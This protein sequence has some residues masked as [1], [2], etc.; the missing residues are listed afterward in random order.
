MG[1]A[2]KR[3]HRHLLCSAHPSV[4]HRLRS[5]C[6]AEGRKGPSGD[7]R[8]VSGSS[9]PREETAASF[10]PQ[11]WSSDW[12]LMVDTRVPGA[13]A[14]SSLLQETRRERPRC[15]SPH[16]ALASSPHR[17]GLTSLGLTPEHNKQ[18]P[19]AG[20]SRPSA[21]GRAWEVMWGP[22][23]KPQETLFLSLEAEVVTGGLSLPGAGEGGG[24][25]LAEATGVKLILTPRG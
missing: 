1:S 22:R 24:S 3:S 25:C 7:L 2:V 18:E 23:W 19:P 12:R 11:L 17:P 6:L 20:G 15:G 13:P 4:G 14:A 9:W 10:V 16:P 5:G 8:R 21:Q